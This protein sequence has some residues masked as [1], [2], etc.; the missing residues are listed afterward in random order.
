M[1]QKLLVVD[2]DGT[3]FVPRRINKLI[4]KKN[5]KF[6]RSFIDSGN[7]VLFSSSRSYEFSKK[8]QEEL[9]RPCSFICCNGSQVINDNGELYQDINFD[10]KELQNIIE[11]IDKKYQPKLLL[12]VCNDYHMAITDRGRLPKF[13][14]YIYR[15][16]NRL[17]FCRKEKFIL[18][19]DI[20]DKELENGIIYKAM[21]F[22]G[23]TKKKRNYSIEVNRYLREEYPEIESV[24]SGYVDELSPKGVNKATSLN[25]FS[26]K[27]GIKKEDIYVIGN[28]GND[29]PMFKEY[30]ENSFA[31]TNSPKVVKKYAKKTITRVFKLNKYLLKGEN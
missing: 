29:I 28:G 14:Q 1:A 31:M 15:F 26:E 9:D 22:F 13:F 20:Y 18:G 19:S 25:L 10:N 21:F 3:L 7:R 17:Q 12:L 6:L 5:L 23:I 27:E 24:W 16:A 4:P 11:G 8:L 2:L 30:Y